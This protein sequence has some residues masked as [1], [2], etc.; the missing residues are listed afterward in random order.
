MSVPRDFDSETRKRAIRVYADRSPGPRTP[1]PSS[2]RRPTCVLP[3]KAD[4]SYRA[5]AQAG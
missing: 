3:D 4:V 5:L 2:P 1:T